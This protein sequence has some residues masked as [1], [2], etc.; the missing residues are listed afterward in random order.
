[1]NQ[2]MLIMFEIMH[3]FEW[4]YL[5]V[6][7]ENSMKELFDQVHV[8]EFVE[9]DFLYVIFLYLQQMIIEIYV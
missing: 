1:M 3:D 2:L 9:K 7:I 4:I 8:I 5:N 6:R